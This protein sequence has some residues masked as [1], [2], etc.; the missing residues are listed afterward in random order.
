ME[1]RTFPAKIDVFPEISEFVESTLNNAGSSMKATVQILIALE[2][3]FVNIA[4]YAYGD[5]KGD[6]VIGISTDDG[7]CTLTFE[8]NGKPFDPLAKADP[9]LSVEAQEKSIGGLG[10]YMVKKSMNSVEYAYRDGKNTLTITKCI[11]ED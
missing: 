6:A 10:I 1:K 11:T 9:D 3:I 4:H 2:E 7:I 5:D 8:D